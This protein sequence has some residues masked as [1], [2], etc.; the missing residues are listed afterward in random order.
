MMR[1]III[2][3]NA[4][5]L[6]FN[7]YRLSLDTHSAALFPLSAKSSFLTPSAARSAAEI[8]S[9]A[10]RRALACGWIRGVANLIHW[11]SSTPSEEGKVGTIEC[12]WRTF[13]EV[14]KGDLYRAGDGWENTLDSIIAGAVIRLQRLAQSDEVERESLLGLL[15]TCMRLSYA[16]VESYLPSILSSL[17]STASSASNSTTSTTTSAFLSALLVHHSRSLL[18][19]ALLLLLSTAL[20]SPSA[21]INNMLTT[22]SWNDELALALTGMVGITTGKCWEDLIDGMKSSIDSVDTTMVDGGVVVVVVGDDDVSRSK[23]RRKTA[24][25]VLVDAPIKNQALAARIRLFSLFVQSLPSPVPL[26]QFKTFHT[27]FVIPAMEVNSGHLGEVLAVRF[28]MIER[29]R[30][31]GV[32]EIGFEVLEL[33]RLKMVSLVK[34]SM[35]GQLVIELVRYFFFS[36]LILDKN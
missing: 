29:M 27:T 24:I 28:R 30:L 32:S 7:L 4:L 22:H 15:G 10:K 21:V 2:V 20:A 8:H 19:P 14:E 9:L 16:S 17:A 5:P 36:N 34:A 33:Q 6:L 12:L 13:E 35:N 18:L 1:F 31:E 23:K 26:G 25:S 3:H 11:S